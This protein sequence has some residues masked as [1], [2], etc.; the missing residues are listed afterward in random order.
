MNK[1]ISLLKN[2]DNRDDTDLEWLQE[3]YEFLQGDCPDKI[4]LGRGHQPKLSRN[5]AFAIIWYLQEHFPVFPDHIEKCSDCGMLYDSHSSGYH[6][7]TRGKFYCGGCMP[8][9]IDE[10]END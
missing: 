8:P 9:F 1:E 6:S 5:K 3:F 4:S 10:E 7:E 2:N